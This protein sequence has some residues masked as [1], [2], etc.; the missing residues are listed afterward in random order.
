MMPTEKEQESMREWLRSR[1]ITFELEKRDYDKTLEI[2][3]IDYVSNCLLI[4]KKYK[5]ASRSDVDFIKKL[6][7]DFEETEVWG[8]R[9]RAP[10]KAAG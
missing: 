7:T 1:R 8:G 6:L 5:L 3:L 9:R 2:K 4:S 10:R